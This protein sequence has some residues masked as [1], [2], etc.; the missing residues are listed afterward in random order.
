MCLVACG[1]PAGRL[2]D[3]AMVPRMPENEDVA[4]VAG[5][6]VCTGLAGSRLCRAWDG[7]LLVFG[8]CCSIAFCWSFAMDALR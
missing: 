4:D 2:C 5:G 3:E 7:L 8:G 6:C 1:L